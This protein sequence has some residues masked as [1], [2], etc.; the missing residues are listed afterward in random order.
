MPLTPPCENVP[1]IPYEK[2]IPPTPASKIEQPRI[3][4]F[5]QFNPTLQQ[6]MPTPIQQ[7]VSTVPITTLPPVQN[8]QMPMQL[9]PG[10]VQ[11]S[12]PLSAPAYQTPSIPVFQ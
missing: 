1:I 6:Y 10:S 3:Y 7:T 5:Y 9:V 4:Q 8:V 12:L 11:M 2:F